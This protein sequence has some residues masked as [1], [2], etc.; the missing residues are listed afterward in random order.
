MNDLIPKQLFSDSY[1]CIGSLFFEDSRV[2]RLNILIQFPLTKQGII[3]G[4][5]IG[6]QQTF[7]QLGELMNRYKGWLNFISKSESPITLELSSN[8]VG[9]KRAANK[10]S[11]NQTPYVVAELEFDELNIATCYP[12]RKFPARI[13]TFYIAGP[14]SM[15]RKLDNRE[16][17][18]EREDRLFSDIVYHPIEL[19][20]TFPFVVKISPKE[21]FDETPAP[22][23]YHLSTYLYTITLETKESLNG[24]SDADFIQMGKELSDDITLLVSFMSRSWT[25]WMRY[26]LQSN[27]CVQTFARKSRSGI[28]R[29]AGREELIV[30]HGKENSFLKATLAGLRKMRSNNS[31]LFLPLIIYVS[32]NEARFVQEKFSSFFLCLEKLKDMYAKDSGKQ[33]IQ[34]S[35]PF[36]EMADDI[37]RLIEERLVDSNEKKLIIEKL[38]E[39][40]R[41][42]F[43]VVLESMLSDYGIN[44]RDIYPQGAQLTLVK[45]RNRLF[46]SS[47]EINSWVLI[48]E[49]QRLRVLVERILLALLGWTDFSQSPPE[50]ERRFLTQ[51]HDS[52]EGE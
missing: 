38:P 43:H 47:E 44:W 31:D 48:R 2:D 25:S 14:H 21:F 35:K 50:H 42:S 28:L 22:E 37:K 11:Y 16:Y 15:W 36:E 32:G 27:G 18:F 33:K 17:K 26:E 39:L 1:N 34:K 4:K 23:S 52:D 24:L 40:N 45:T 13:L 3:A 10:Y 49:M 7:Y 29:D 46:H 5:V 8:K 51:S 19:K 41:P 12:D 30:D 9:V 6:N 20:E